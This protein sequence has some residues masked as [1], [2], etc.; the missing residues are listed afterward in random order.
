MSL[1][2]LSARIRGPNVKANPACST[3]PARLICPSKLAISVFRRLT[4]CFAASRVRIASWTPELAFT[5]FS[6]TVCRVDAIC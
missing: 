1:S 4:R 3:K 6:L 5:N 2:A